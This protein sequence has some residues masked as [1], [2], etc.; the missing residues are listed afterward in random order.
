MRARQQGATTV[1]FALALLLFLTFLLAILDLGRLLFTWNAASE[2]ARLGARYAVVCDDTGQQAQVLARMQGVLPQ[3][4]AIDVAWSPP[5]CDPASC[6]GVTVSI[7]NLAFQWISPLAGVAAFAPLP[8]S[9]F[10][11]FIPR[12]VMRQDPNSAAICS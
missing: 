4:T 2:A 12:E 7:T 6:E 10:P 5:S 8:M 9:T 11:T 1:E 3:I